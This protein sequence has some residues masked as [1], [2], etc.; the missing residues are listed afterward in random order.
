M[1]RKLMLPVVEYQFLCFLKLLVFFL[2][3][4]F[5]FCFGEVTTSS[6]LQ[7]HNQQ[8]EALVPSS[9]IDLPLKQLV[10][11][12]PELKGISPPPNEQALGT[13]LQNTG[14]R[15]DEFLANVVAT[16]GQEDIAQQREIS[17]GMPGGT[18]QASQHMQ[19][20]YLILRTTDSTHQLEEFRMDAKGN[21]MDESGMDKGFFVTSGFA[22]SSVHFATQFQWDSRFLYLGDQKIDGRDTYVVAFAQLPS[23][24]RIAVT[25]QG[26]NGK[27]FRMLCQGIAWIDKASFHLLQLRTD[28]L[29][30]RPE[31]GLDQQ[32]TK[33]A[34]S[35][36]RFADLAMPL[37]LPHDVNVYVR[38]TDR[39]EALQYGNQGD[40]V[41]LGPHVTDQTFRNMHRYSNYQRYRVSTKILQ[42]H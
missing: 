15:V 19:D 10:K 4:V 25:I 13:I 33:I 2:L 24:G 20:S 22:L 37:W 17:T 3:L 5:S 23:E 31:I 26:R 7:D 9:Y 12:I 35:E 38:F 36:V 14:A 39:S 30:P 11:R 29:A 6:G 41:D 18:M 32:T 16:V 1:I 40:V 28:L 42:S 8:S 27:T 21:R 34:Y